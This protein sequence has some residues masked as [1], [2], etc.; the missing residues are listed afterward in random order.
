MTRTSRTFDRTIAK[1][2]TAGSFNGPMVPN[3]KAPDDGNM[4]GKDNTSGGCAN[5]LIV[6]GSGRARRSTLASRRSRVARARRR[7]RERHG[8]LDALE[9]SHASLAGVRLIVVDDGPQA[10]SMLNLILTAR[11][12]FVGAEPPRLEGCEA[13]SSRSPPTL[14]QH[15][16]EYAEPPCPHHRAGPVLDIELAI[17]I[18]QVPLERAL[19]DEDRLGDF[20]VAQA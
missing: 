15:R 18:V 7:C 13:Q 10:N 8:A 2:P 4:C 14:R 16:S 20:L 11:L 17:D 5:V 19:R 3:A 9:P 6:R 1:G 12:T